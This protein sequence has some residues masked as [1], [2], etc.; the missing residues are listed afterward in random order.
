MMLTLRD[1]HCGYQTTLPA[2]VW[3]VTPSSGLEGGNIIVDLVA[4]CFVPSVV[5]EL[6]LSL[7]SNSILQSVFVMDAS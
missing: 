3:A 1:Q 4:N 2:P 6:F 7:P 5:S